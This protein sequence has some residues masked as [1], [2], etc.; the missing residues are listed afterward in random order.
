MSARELAQPTSFEKNS[1]KPKLSGLKGFHV[2]SPVKAS[3]RKPAH[4]RF[5]SLAEPAP[6]EVWD[7]PLSQKYLLL[8]EKFKCMDLIVNMLQQRGET[9]TFQKLKLAVE[10]MLRRYVCHI[11]AFVVL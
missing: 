5:Q 1:P 3:P 8:A 6:D 10:E 7:L 2:A 9:C 11:K 4:Q